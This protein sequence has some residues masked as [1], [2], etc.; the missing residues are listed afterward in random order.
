MSTKMY[1]LLI[2]IAV[3]L[4]NG[5]SQDKGVDAARVPMPKN[6]H[7]RCWCRLT[8]REFSWNWLGNA[9]NISAVGISW[10][11]PFDVAGIL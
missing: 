7:F 9:A 3:V 1:D 11:E 4:M 8:R 2:G 10:W 6:Y 5:P